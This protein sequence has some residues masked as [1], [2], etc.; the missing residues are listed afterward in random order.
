LEQQ[1][2]RCRLHQQQNSNT[3]RRHTTHTPAQHLLSCQAAA[4][5][6]AKNSYPT[7]AC[8]SNTRARPGQ[9]TDPD[10]NPDPAKI[11]HLHCICCHVGLQ[12][13]SAATVVRSGGGGWQPLPLIK[14]HQSAT[15]PTAAIKK[16]PETALDA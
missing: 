14:P 15:A 7:A 8:S 6:L 16:H 5:A 1:L 9:D 12:Q 4:A 11:P 10:Q 3:Q 2:N 13:L